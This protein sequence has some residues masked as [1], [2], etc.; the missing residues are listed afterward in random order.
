MGIWRPTNKSACALIVILSS[1]TAYAASVDEVAFGIAKKNACLGCHSV[2][3][4]IVGPSYQDVA[5]RY[6]NSPSAVSFLKNKIRSGGVGSWG[7][8]P[9]PANTSL[10]EEDAALLA[11]WILRG[12]PS[13]N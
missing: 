3:K 8:V 12:T 13:Q 7:V 2:N 6:K 5:L 9:M 10:S 1:S 4:K 11:Q